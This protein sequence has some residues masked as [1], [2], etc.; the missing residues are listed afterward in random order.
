MTP[1]QAMI[2][3]AEPIKDVASG[4]VF[5]IVNCMIYAKMISDVRIK[6]T[7]VGLINFIDMKRIVCWAIPRMA[8]ANTPIHCPIS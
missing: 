1:M 5:I 2:T 6:L 8:I 4:S 3:N 7:N